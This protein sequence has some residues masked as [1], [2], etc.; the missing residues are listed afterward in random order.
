[1]MNPNHTQYL[2]LVLRNK[3]LEKTTSDS[4][5]HENSVQYLNDQKMHQFL[6]DGKFALRLDEII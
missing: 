6:I 2:S 4:Q 3:V 1:M 5:D